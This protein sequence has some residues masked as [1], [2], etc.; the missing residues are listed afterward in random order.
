MSYNFLDEIKI[1]I[2]NNDVSLDTECWS[3]DRN[4]KTPEFKKDDGTCEQCNG[5]GYTLTN[6]GEAIIKL[7][8]RHN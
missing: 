5:I 6:V 8:K 2:L 1:D 7:V 3:C 4:R